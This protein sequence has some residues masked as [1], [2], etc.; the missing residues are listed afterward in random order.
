MSL[1]YLGMDQ[2]IDEDLGPLVIETTARPGLQ[3]QHVFGVG[4]AECV[5][6]IGGYRQAALCRPPL[7]VNRNSAGNFFASDPTL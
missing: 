1:D 3:S 4:L 7:K 6:E 5:K 2:M